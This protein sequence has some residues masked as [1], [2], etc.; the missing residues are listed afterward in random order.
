MYMYITGGESSFG[1][2]ASMLNSHSVNILKTMKYTDNM[3]KPDT[4]TLFE[5]NMNEFNR[6]F[7]E[8]NKR[9]ERHELIEQNCARYIGM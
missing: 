9:V 8:L 5:S 7:C 3:I 2:F 1:V 6:M 4:R